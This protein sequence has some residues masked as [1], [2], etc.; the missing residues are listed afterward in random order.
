MK[1]NHPSTVE[2]SAAQSEEQASLDTDL[3]P[4]PDSIEAVMDKEEKD[5]MEQSGIYQIK[6]VKSSRRYIGSSQIPVYKRVA[7]HKKLLAN[8]V[9][10]SVKLQ[11]AWDKYGAE[12]FEVFV[13]E[14]VLDPTQLLPIEQYWI[15]FYKAATKGYNMSPTAGS[16][17]GLSHSDETKQKM[18][19]AHLGKE[20]TA[21]HRANLS[22]ANLGKKMSLESRQ[23][24]SEAKLGKPRAPHSSETREL[25]SNIRKGIKFAPST[26][27]KM[28]QAKMGKKQSQETI[29]KRRQ[30]LLKTLKAPG[31]VHPKKRV[32]DTTDLSG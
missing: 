13:L 9:H 8:G 5:P 17:K 12:Q 32:T 15:D 10:H 21:E 16:L 14:T 19:K 28:A 23:K 24:M 11:R 31:Y 4:K 2:V 27:E 3:A 22:K 1:P 29:D 18:S 25:M 30:S 6:H 20:R 7:R 26:L